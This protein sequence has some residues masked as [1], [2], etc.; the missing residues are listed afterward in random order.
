ML[1]LLVPFA[2]LCLW[3]YIEDTSKNEDFSFSSDKFTLTVSACRIL[4]KKGTND[5]LTVHVNSKTH[6]EFFNST[7]PEDKFFNTTDD[8]MKMLNPNEDIDACNLELE[9]ASFPDLEIYCDKLLCP[10]TQDG[11][12][13]VF[14][15]VLNIT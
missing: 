4:L 8:S 15:G 3:V 14:S 9:S 6:A 7:E 5:D 10:I 13:L 2:I 1:F 11:N 12:D